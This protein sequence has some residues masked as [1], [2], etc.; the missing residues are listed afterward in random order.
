MYF[1]LRYIL[2][3]KFQLLSTDYK[4]VRALNVYLPDLEVGINRECYWGPK[5]VLFRLVFR[6][7]KKSLSK[8]YAFG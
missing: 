3:E 5:N 6:Y 2:V 8:D 7:I 4:M 1:Y